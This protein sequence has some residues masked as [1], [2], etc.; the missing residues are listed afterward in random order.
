MEDQDSI[1][2]WS[3]SVERYFPG[4]NEQDCFG[5]ASWFVNG[6]LRIQ[7]RADIVL[8]TIP[9]S[10]PYPTMELVQLDGTSRLI[11]ID[12]HEGTGTHEAKLL[13]AGVTVD[14]VKTHLHDGSSLSE[15]RGNKLAVDELL[16]H[17]YSAWRSRT[18]PNDVGYL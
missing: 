4:K 3:S 2:G 13:P 17:R 12:R 10:V 7:G 14:A 11:V 1:P 16:A 18:E 5:G 6:I 8:F 9:D 15:L